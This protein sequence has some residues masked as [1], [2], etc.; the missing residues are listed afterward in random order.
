VD[1]DD[2]TGATRPRATQVPLPDEIR[3][4]RALP[5]ADFTYACRIDPVAADGRTAEQWARAVFEGAPRLVRLSIVGGWIAGLGLRLGSTRSAQYVLGWT[6]EASSPD[7]VILGVRS[8][9]LT[10]RV[11]VRVSPSEVVHATLVRYDRRLAR[12]VWP[13]AAVIHR[14]LVPHLLQHAQAQLS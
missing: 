4:L 1:A 13:A 7:V 10:A 6:I 5:D 2:S 3:A 14:L 12:L 9:M 11:V 8:F